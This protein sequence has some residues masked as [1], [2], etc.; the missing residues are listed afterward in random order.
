MVVTFFVGVF[1]VVSKSV[2]EEK[3][4]SYYKQTLFFDEQNKCL[5]GKEIVGFVNDSDNILSHVC[6]HLYPNAF[7]QASKASVV[8]LANQQ[9]AYPNGKDYGNIE[10]E[11]VCAGDKYLEFEV[12]GEDENILIVQF[13]KEI[14]PEELFEFEIGFC[15]NLANVNHRLGYGNNTINLCNYYPVLCVYENGEFITDLYN[16]NGD[17]FYSKLANYEVSITYNKNYILAST[18]VQKN[19]ID[20]ENK[21]TT[22][23]A[24][25][26]RDFAMVLSDKYSIETINYDDVEINYYY[27]DDTNIKST[28]QVITEVLDMNKKYGKYPYPQISVAE[29]NFVHG[30]MEYPNIVLISDDLADYDTYINVVVHELCHQWWYG[31]VG[32]N[33]YTYGFLDEGLTDY[34]TA[35]FYDAYPQYGMTSQNIFNNAAN[36]YATFTKIYTDV[37]GENFS[38]S[39]IRKLNEFKTESEY[40]YL[41]YVK[42][43]LMFASLEDLLGTSKMDKCLKVYYNN[44]KFLEATPDDLVSAFVKTSGKNLYSFFNSW[45]N[46]EVVIG[47]F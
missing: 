14:Y 24:K 21:V 42:G 6:L 10:I 22:I 44:N 33:Q 38:T 17:P 40:V 16:S 19:I 43:M 13:G 18:G 37:Q 3:N 9:K 31:I 11:S 35:K 7:R 46:G 2:S 26:V 4:L 23:T 34:N 15:V 32:N 29:A 39:M 8:S 28:M 27:Y 25:N 20:G 30:G 47:E 41:T 5:D 12:G 1:A 45:F 36:G